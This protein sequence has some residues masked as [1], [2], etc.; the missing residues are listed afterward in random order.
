MAPAPG[1]SF[2]GLGRLRVHTTPP[3]WSQGPALNQALA[4]LQQFDL[5][6]FGH[7]SAAYLHHLIEAVKLVFSDRELYYGDAGTST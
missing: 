5:G 3:Q 6:S 4:I 7:N 1:R 2:P